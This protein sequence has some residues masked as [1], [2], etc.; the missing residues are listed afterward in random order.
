MVMLIFSIFPLS[1]ERK[2]TIFIREDKIEM[3]SKLVEK[4]TKPEQNQTSVDIF[5]NSFRGRLDLGEL[6]E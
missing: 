5:Q 3:P 6:P 2:G 1:F 4:T